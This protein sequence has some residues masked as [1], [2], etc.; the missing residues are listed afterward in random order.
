MPFRSLLFFL[1]AILA[2][3]FVFLSFDRVTSVIPGW[4]TT[5]NIGPN[6]YNVVFPVMLFAASL[7]YRTLSRRGFF[8]SRALFVSHVCFTILP[9][10][11]AHFGLLVFRPGFYSYD[12]RRLMFLLESTYWCQWLLLIMQVVFIVLLITKLFSKP[13]H[14][15]F[16]ANS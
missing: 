10:L 7:L 12:Y 1:L 15:T 16:P 14:V 6:W 8:I 3:L 5:V 11:Y 9:Y 4:H 13:P 2:L